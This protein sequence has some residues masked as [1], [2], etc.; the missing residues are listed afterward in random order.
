MGSVHGTKRGSCISSPRSAAIL[1]IAPRMWV[2]MA[3]PLG[4]PIWVP[5]NSR[6]S[7][8]SSLVTSPLFNAA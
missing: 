5:K 2:F 3:E 8:I 7:S 1:A 6:N 4:Q